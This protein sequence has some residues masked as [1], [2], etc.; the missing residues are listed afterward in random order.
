M[1]QNTE[2][3]KWMPDK[4]SIFRDNPGTITHLKSS[5][6][7]LEYSFDA[8]GRRRNKY[9]WDYSATTDNSL[10][11]NRGFTGHEY[12][13]QFGLYNMNGRLYDPLIG[14][15]LSPDKYVQAPYFSQDFNRYGY[16]L[17]N[18]LKYTDPSGDFLL[19]LLLLTDDGY[20]LQKYLFPVA[21]H[22]GLSSGNEQQYRGI[23][24]SWGVPQILPI[25]YRQ[26][27]G[28][29]YYCKDYDG[30]YSGWEK[31][32]GAEWSLFYSGLS[33]ADTYYDREGTKFDQY[34]NVVCLGP[35]VVNLQ[36]ENDLS[37]Q[38]VFKFPWM[39][40]H[41]SSDKFLTTQAKLKTG[42]MEIGLTLFTG[43]PGPNMAS[44]NWDTEENYTKGV[45]GENPDEFRA[46]ILYVGFGP[47][48]FGMNSESIRDHT[49]N[50]VHRNLTN[51]PTFR[52]LPRK[53]KF[54]WQIF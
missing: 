32:S 54:Y 23:D 14:R 45:N 19:S 35:P 17:N 9:T 12:L 41:V 24:V 15:F 44:R 5:S 26:H 50:W 11:I 37:F 40:K 16:C 18:P 39:P 28:K 47:I 43:D 49:Q 2:I 6:E 46:G 27:S 4:S 48:K 52:V 22:I 42:F 20:D 53:P 31:R 30:S 3:I 21:I 34:R 38:S 1:N 33:Y 7:T 8:F 13:E 36:F 25:S 51:D 29:Y 10:F